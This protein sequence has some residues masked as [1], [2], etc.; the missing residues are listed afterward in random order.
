MLSTVFSQ[1]SRRLPNKCQ[2]FKVE[3]EINKREIMAFILTR[4]YT[5][6]PRLSGLA[7]LV[8]FFSMNINKTVG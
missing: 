7:S 3:F 2:V 4:L 6:G 5:V 1:Y 8:L